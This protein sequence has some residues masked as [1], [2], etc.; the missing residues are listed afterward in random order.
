MSSAVWVNA[1]Y[2]LAAILFIV[3]LKGLS[4]PKSA[5]RGNMIGA[6]GMLIAIVVVL[7]DQQVLNW[8][9]IVAGI[10]VGSIIGAILALRIQ[11]TAMPQLV[12]LFNGLLR[13]QGESH[14]RSRGEDRK[15][16]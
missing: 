9:Y 11:M 10:A 5:V 8:T 15:R 12:G 2:L 6:F 16:Q 3:G 14:P 4:H 7:V 1:A 13:E